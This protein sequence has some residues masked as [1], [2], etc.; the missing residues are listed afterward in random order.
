MTTNLSKDSDLPELLDEE[1]LRYAAKAMKLDCEHVDARGAVIISQDGISRWWWSPL[2]DR[3]QALCV[4]CALRLD[5]EHGNELDNDRYVY[6]SRHGIEVVRSPVG[7]MEEIGE[8]GWRLHITCRA[9]VRAAAEI[10]KEI[11]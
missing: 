7:I 6:V 3:G 4:A 2:E 1:I 8:E 11:S 9:I 10:G 5:I